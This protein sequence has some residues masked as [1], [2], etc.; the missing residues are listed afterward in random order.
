MRVLVTGG[1]GFLGRAL[2]A[3]LLERG[4][5]VVVLDNLSSPSPLGVPPGADF[6][7][8]DVIAPPPLT[9]PFERIYHLASPASPPRYLRDPIGTL[10]S[11]AEGTRQMLELAA[12]R[13]ARFI[14]TSTS[15]VYGDPEVH[16]QSEDYPGAVSLSAERACY[17]EG[18]RY[19]EALVYAYRRAGIVTDSRVARIFNTYGPGMDP[20]DGRIISN[21]LVQALQGRPLTI[22]GSGHQ[23][24][25]FCYVAD[26]VG[27]LMRLADSACSLPVNLGNPEEV[28]I[29]DVADLVAATV[30]DTGR[31]YRPLPEGDPKRRCPDITRAQQELGWRPSVTLSDGV[32]RTRA[33]FEELR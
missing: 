30:G 24:R 25:S 12:T 16:P 28:T 8:G 27:G 21:F 4:D 29:N 5:Q 20:E 7:L 18:K 31:E 3:R 11:N 2:V 23:T 17:D 15:E 19:A 6:I 33:Y 10:R 22:Y 9:G 26:L 1:A 32:G 13:G 14:L